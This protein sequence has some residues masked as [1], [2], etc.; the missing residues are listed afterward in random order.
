MQPYF[1]KLLTSKK[2]LLYFALFLLLFGTVFNCS[3]VYVKAAERKEPVYASEYLKRVYL[4]FN[5]EFFWKYNVN[6]DIFTGKAYIDVKVGKDE[7]RTKDITFNNDGSMDKYNIPT[8]VEREL[9]DGF[10][11][12]PYVRSYKLAYMA[13]VFDAFGEPIT[14]EEKER[15]KKSP[16]ICRS[17]FMI[18]CTF[19]ELIDI[20]CAGEANYRRNFEITAGREHGKGECL[21]NGIT[22][23]EYGLELGDEISYCGENGKEMGKLKISGFFRYTLWG[24][25]MDDGEVLEPFRYLNSNPFFRK[26]Y[27]AVK[28]IIITDFDTAYSVDP[29]GSRE[30]NFYASLYELDDYRNFE[31]FVEGC[32]EFENSWL[33]RFISDY[34]LYDHNASCVLQNISLGGRFA[35]VGAVLFCA[36]LAA[37]SVFTVS[38][39]GKDNGILRA[40]GVKKRII[41]A[42]YGVFGAVFAAAVS[43]ISVLTGYLLAVGYPLVDKWVARENYLLHPEPESFLFC[44]AAFVVGGITAA[45]VTLIQLKVF[46]IPELL[47]R[48]K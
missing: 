10:A 42:N 24:I 1:T 8:Y 4:R 48:E 34:Q 2:Q 37:L 13:Q 18:G 40:L 5:P 41:A 45:A 6:Y 19:D 7:Y 46:S 17:H 35:A 31:A 43:L 36:A 12:Q 25:K 15:V 23:A 28:Y 9:F 30:I 32:G 14:E 38:S 44:A 33:M 16:D 22:A 47:G 29:E 20:F 3:V 27:T 39:K 21:I 26:Q 11:R